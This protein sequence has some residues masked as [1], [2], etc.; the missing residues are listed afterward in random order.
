M[1]RSVV[2]AGRP[3]VGKS[4]LFN[5]ILR[6][7]HAITDPTPGVTR[8]AIR[9]IA[10][11]G[12]REVWLVDTGGVTNEAGPFDQIVTRNALEE[13]EKGDVIV[14]L[15]DVTGLTPEDEEIIE[16]VRRIGG[17]T[18][19]AVNKVDSEKREQDLWNFYSL[20]FEKTIG[21]S[22]AHGLGI[23]D[24]EDAIL[25]YLD[26]LDQAGADLS[27]ITKEEL[28]AEESGEIKIAVLGQPNTGKSSLMNRF[29]NRDRALV[30]EIPGTTRDVVEER[31][32]YKGR[33]F[34]ILDTAGMR[35]RAKVREN[36]EYY[37]VQRAVHAIDE[38]DVVCL[39]VDA[40]KGLVEQDKKIASLVVD[41]GRGLILALNKW[42]LLD[43]VGNQEA[44]L[45]DR[46]RFLFPVLSFAPITP[47]SAVTGFGISRLLGVIQE[48]YGQ[49]HRRVETS[50]LN[51]ALRAWVA[52]TP[53]PSGRK[54]W[55]VRYMTQ[56]STHPV[57]FVA[58]VNRASDF[59]RFYYQFLLNRIRRE[60]G[61]SRVPIALELRDNSR[62]D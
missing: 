1:R 16:A 27:E 14:L 45:V 28:R 3:N 17:P 10:E 7:R 47:T 5:R 26:L 30:S 52:E 6:R 53:P 8:D 46:I 11:V 41:R 9:T 39:V 2:I 60:L 4:T 54:R 22:A 33:P 57:R 19:C 58:F 40:R 31:F 55:K 24:L 44:A 12:N 61:F 36:V 35:R 15:L 48:V 62:R 25:D 38:A 21:I 59:P 49:L 20:G 34:R 51:T 42:D 56:V 29:L 32:E 50:Q 18:V 13:M 23:E 43:D 37:S